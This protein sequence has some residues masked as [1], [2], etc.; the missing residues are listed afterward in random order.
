MAFHHATTDGLTGMDATCNTS[1]ANGTDNV[2]SGSTF[3]FPTHAG[4]AS[5]NSA[6]LT[7]IDG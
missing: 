4:V 6:T 7:S 2:P 1:S 3:T 5:N